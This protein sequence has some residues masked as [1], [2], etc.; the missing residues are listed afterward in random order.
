MQQQIE[1]GHEVAFAGAE[2]A[3]EISRFT[4]SEASIGSE[5]IPN[6]R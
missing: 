1:H 6:Q 5:R 3:M 4:F 2:T